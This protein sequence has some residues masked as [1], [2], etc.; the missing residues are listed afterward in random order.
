MDIDACY[1]LWLKLNHPSSERPS[2][3]L[4]T[5]SEDTP[6]CSSPLLSLSSTP[7]QAPVEPCSQKLPGVEAKSKLTHFLSIPA[8]PRM[9][10]STSTGTRTLT[11]EEYMKAM[12]EKQKKEEAEQRE[13]SAE[14]KGRRR[15]RSEKA[16]AAIKKS[17]E[18]W[19]KK[20]PTARNWLCCKTV[21]IILI[22]YLYTTSI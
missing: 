1:N 14:L 5:S 15:G 19:K 17:L 12:D 3:K 21:C 16:K 18:Q 4:L 10:G 6:S 8:P 13:R 20:H 7:R 2:L 9:K 11:S 22:L